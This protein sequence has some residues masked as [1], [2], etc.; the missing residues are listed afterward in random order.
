[1][2]RLATTAVPSSLVHHRLKG[3]CHR[4]LADYLNLRTVLRKL[5]GHDVRYSCRPPLNPPHER[6]IQRLQRAYLRRPLPHEGCLHTFPLVC[7]SLV[8]LIFP[9]KRGDLICLLRLTS[10]QHAYVWSRCTSLC[11]PCLRS[12]VWDPFIF[13]FYSVSSYKSRFALASQPLRMWGEA[14]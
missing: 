5:P 3:T 4:S 13:L 6:R 1:M 11:S 2:S 10:C 8:P 7:T 12:A 14:T 9:G